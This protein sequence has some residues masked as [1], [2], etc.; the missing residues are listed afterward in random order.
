LILEEEDVT[1]SSQEFACTGG[2][3]EL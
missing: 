3:C 1:T 2:A